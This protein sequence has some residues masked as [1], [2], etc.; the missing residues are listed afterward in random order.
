MGLLYHFIRFNTSIRFYAILVDCWSALSQEQ[1]EA[2][3]KLLQ[4]MNQ[5]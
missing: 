3:L 4:L 2:A 5:K 1:R